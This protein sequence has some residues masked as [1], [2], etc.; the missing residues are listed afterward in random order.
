MQEEAELLARLPHEK[1][2]MLRVLE[3]PEGSL[4]RLVDALDHYHELTIVPYWPRCS[5]THLEAD[6]LRRGQALLLG[7]AETFFC[8]EAL[9]L[10]RE[11]GN[12]RGVSRALARLAGRR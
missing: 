5:R 3:D 10:Y 12:D 4:K 8:D 2:R 6:V 11:L 9:N 7:G 1:V